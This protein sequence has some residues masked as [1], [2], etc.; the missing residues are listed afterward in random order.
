MCSLAP[1][2]KLKSTTPTPSPQINKDRRVHTSYAVG[3]QTDAGLDRSNPRT[4]RPDDS[5][6]APRPLV[7]RSGK[8]ISPRNTPDRLRLAGTW[9]VPQPARPSPRA[10]LHNSTPGIVR[11]VSRE[12]SWPDDQ[13]RDPLGIRVGPCRTLASPRRWAGDHRRLFERF[14]GSEDIAENLT[15]SG[16][17][18]TTTLSAQE[19]F[20]SIRAGPTSGRAPRG[21]DQARSGTSAT[22]SERQGGWAGDGT[23]P[24]RRG[25]DVSGHDGWFRVPK[26]M[27]NRRPWY[28]PCQAGPPS[29]GTLSVRSGRLGT[30]RTGE[31]N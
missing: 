11:R 20:P 14:R 22:S 25:P 16:S 27:S 26:A 9:R 10:G 17:R 5:A 1:L 6:G 18:R 29:G 3:A 30:G 19:H 28:P 13:F 7:A 23:M 24:G 2:S 15:K 12:P 4:I 31:A 8:L 21:G